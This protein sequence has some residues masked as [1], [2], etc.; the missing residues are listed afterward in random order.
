MW[1]DLGGTDPHVTMAGVNVPICDDVL[2]AA[3]IA[4]GSEVSADLAVRLIVLE[5][6]Y[7]ILGASVDHGTN[8][9]QTSDLRR[10]IKVDG[11]PSVLS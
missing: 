10:A 5:G 7:Q 3:G 2:V 4:A 6:V 9:I 11:R 8:R 1:H